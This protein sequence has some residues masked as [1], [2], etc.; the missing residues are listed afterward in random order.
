[1]YCL[2]GKNKDGTD[3]I[4]YGDEAYTKRSKLDVMCPIQ[5][6]IVT[7]WDDMEKVI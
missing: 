6:G 4:Y 7:N 5:R 2:R 1:M 3:G